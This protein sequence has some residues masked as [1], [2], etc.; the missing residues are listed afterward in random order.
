LD[1]FG[2][3]D[4]EAAFERYAGLTISIHCEDSWVLSQNQEPTHEQRRPAEAEIASTL[5]TLEM[6]EKYNIKAKICH[7]STKEGLEAI[8]AAKKARSVC[9]L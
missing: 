7:F 5:F 2:T 1:F 8:G 6:I 9:H 3:E 4:A